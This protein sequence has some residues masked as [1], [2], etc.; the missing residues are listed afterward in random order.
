MK[1]DRRHFNSIAHYTTALECMHSEF[2]QENPLPL[3][4]GQSKGE[5]RMG[6]QIVSKF[7]PRKLS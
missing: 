7:I 2:G 5:E 1:E 3:A 4:K 6:A